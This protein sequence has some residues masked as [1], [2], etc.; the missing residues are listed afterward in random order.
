MMD[1]WYY[2]DFLDDIDYMPEKNSLFEIWQYEVSMILIDN[3]SK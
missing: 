3:H 1:S 2:E